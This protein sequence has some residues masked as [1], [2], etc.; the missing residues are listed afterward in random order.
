M[1]EKYTKT[2]HI[3]SVVSFLAALVIGFI[4]MFIPP[5]GIIDP[6]ILYYTAQLLVFTSGFL[7]VDFNVNI[8]RFGASTKKIQKHNREENNEED[9]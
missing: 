7:G 3:L 9:I 4:A 5:K 6:S 2:K 1:N 8:G